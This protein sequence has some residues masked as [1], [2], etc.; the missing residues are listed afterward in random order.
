MVLSRRLKYIVR[1]LVWSFI[2]IH[3]GLIV[4]LN[5]PS[6]QGKLAT[7]VS[8]ELGRLLHTEVAV[9]RIELGLLNRI[10]ITDVRL[11]DQQGEEMLNVNRLSARFE[12]RPLLEGKIVINSVQLIGF[13]IRLQ[14]DTPESVPNFQFVLDALAS[15]DTL[16]QAPKIDLRINS[17][18]INRGQLTYDVLSEPQTAEKFNASH[19]GIQ[20]LSASIS[21]KALRNDSL[22]AIVRR[23]SFEEQSGFRLEKLGMKLI[24][25][26]NHLNVNGF[27]INLPSSSLTLDSVEVRYDSLQ[28]LPKMTDDVVFKGQLNGR[29][30]LSDV[31]PILPVLKEM[32]EPLNL[33]A[34]FKGEGK[35]V[36][37]PSLSLSDRRYLTIKGKASVQNWAAKQNMYLQANLTN[38]SVTKSGI[39]Y[40]MNNLTGSVPPILQRLEFVQFRGTAD[41]YLRD[42]LVNGSLQTGAGSLRADMLINTDENLNRTYTG[43]L[44]SDNLHL[45]TLLG[46]NKFGQ[47]NFNIELEGFNYQNKYPESNI[48]GVISSLEYSGY[49]YEN[50]TMDGLYKD[51]GFNGHLALDDE[52]GAIQID[53]SFNTSRRVSDFNLQASVK[54]L[55]PNELNISDKYVD[56]DISLLLTANFTGSSINDM[57]GS[58][59]LD[60]L[61][62]NAPEDQGYVLDNLTILAGQVG[63]EKEVRIQSPFLTATVRGDYSYQTIPASVVQIAQRH[64]PSLVTLKKKYRQSLNNNFKFDIQLHDAE[65]FNKM[66]FIPVEMH[67]PA[68]LKGY[69]SDLNGQLRIEGSFPGLTY[70]GTRYESATL[71]FENPG[72]HIKCQ[73]RGG[74]LMNSGAMLNLSLDTEAQEDRL[75]TVLNW[76]NNTDVTYGGQVSA[77]THF[78]KTEGPKPILQADVE[79]LPTTVVLN[80]TV[81][82]IRSSHVAVDSGR[83]YVDNFLFER[84]GQHLRIDGKITQEPTDSCIIDLKNIDVQYV[85]DIV[86][87]DDIEFGG[88]ATGKVHLKNILDVPDMRTHLKVHNFAVNKGLMGEADIRGAWDNELPGIRLEAQMEEK[89]LSST[90]V[91]GFVSPQLKALDLHINA[92][93]TNLDLLVPYFDGIFSELDARATGFVRLHGGFKTLDFDGGVKVNLDAKVDALNTYIQL[94]ND[95]VHLRPGEFALHN[96]RI[97]DREGNSGR[98]TGALR[99]THLKNLNYQF[100]IQSNNLLL[101]HT[102]DPGDMLFYGK[103]YGTGTLSLDGGNNAMNV[104][105]NLTTGPKTTFTYVTGL[106]TEATSNQFITFVD[107]T[108]KRVQDDIKTEFYHFSDASQKEEDDG[109]PMDLRIQ[110]NI[111]ATPDANMKV[112]MDPVAGDNITA[113]GNGNFQ[114]SYYNKGDF[115]MFGN[116]TIDSGMYKLSMQEI[117]R[118]DFSLQSGSTVTFTGDPYQA[119]LDVQAVYTVNSVS[120]SDL[121]TDAS[122]N[123][124]TVKVNCLMNLTGSLASPT[125]KFDL[126]LP[127]ISEE[128]RE[129]VR[130]ATSTEE[131]MNTQIIYLL[132]IG[133]F[134]AYDYNEN[135]NQSSSATSSLAFSTLSGQ[136]NNMLSQ[137]MENKNWNIGA[138][139]STGQEGWSD[140]EAEAILSGRLLNNR[141]LIN[142]NFGYRENVM[143]NTNFVGDF[144]AVWLLTKNGEF[145]L[146]GY[147]QTNDRYFTKS[148]LTT[149][150]IGF[151]YKKDFNRWHDLF[152]WLLRKQNDKKEKEK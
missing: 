59:R 128:D 56:S 75:R 65:L 22:N 80:D 141:L 35:N 64:I 76:G 99:H 140:V 30:V 94:H 96:A 24:A 72:D 143:A 32:N 46:D 71:L 104:D 79:I 8:T 92:D 44:V 3:I 28:N 108:P 85:L 88:L 102:T 42:L 101:Y 5:I 82:N 126:D 14:K 41:G 57:N 18:L 9:G 34:E 43:E 142:G 124:S 110:M 107:K 105:A 150:G 97:F 29:F 84:P 10:H 106:T 89:N 13:D 139:F 31:A 61:V 20:N 15:K 26:N 132:G 83:V 47:T 49:R 1:I 50:I 51:G 138:N 144:E 86:Q 123:Q 103:V 147:N 36:E 119:N 6:V 137:V 136:L 120:L 149:Q 112:V 118:K 37:I 145:R 16:K 135:T 122:L 33:S 70:N 25:D 55:R 113:R 52:N 17:V 152:L 23:L 74:M 133:K 115:R 53:G 21:L 81:W 91:T 58:I 66:F 4:L 129:L 69:V 100:D 125:I 73:I 114:V 130:S 63:S 40:F 109:P 98:I 148:T 2:G 95:S 77:V 7:L 11:D 68:S 54:N 38:L 12:W 67:F 60:S 116:Y 62:M 90:H 131:Q 78:Y 27:N 39:G 121:S 151:I 134:Y 45:G 87:F 93:S 19:I 146:R 48:K 117:I 111:D 127:T